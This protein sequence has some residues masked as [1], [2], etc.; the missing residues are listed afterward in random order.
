[1]ADK[2]DRLFNNLRELVEGTTDFGGQ[3]MATGSDPVREMLERDW[4]HLDSAEIGALGEKFDEA[5]EQ[6]TDARLRD[7]W[8]WVQGEFDR[9]RRG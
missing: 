3:T 7:K 9:L 4:S 1:M 8:R 5:V 2:A 6:A